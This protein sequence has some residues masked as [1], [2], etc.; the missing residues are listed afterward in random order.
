MISKYTCVFSLDRRSN[1][2]G[3]PITENVPIYAD[4]SFKQRL[5][6][7]TGYRIDVSR[8]IDEKKKD[9]KTGEVRVMQKMIKI[10]ADVV[11]LA[12]FVK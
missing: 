6:Y 1:A 7:P 8:W 10:F 5:R 12:N 11:Y 2:N 9:E 4:I 3:I